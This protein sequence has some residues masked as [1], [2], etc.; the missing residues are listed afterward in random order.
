LRFEGVTQRLQAFAFGFKV[1]DDAVVAH[2]GHGA[3]VCAFFARHPVL[4]GWS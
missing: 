2:R 3:G 1:F 4:R